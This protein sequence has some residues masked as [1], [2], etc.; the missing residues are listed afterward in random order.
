MTHR[1]PY[2]RVVEY[3]SIFMAQCA[4]CGDVERAHSRDAAKGYSKEHLRIVH[5]TEEQ[6][7]AD[8][9]GVAES[10]LPGCSRCGHEDHA[11]ASCPFVQPYLLKDK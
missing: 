8:R 11:S 6:Q 2:Q 7:E 10:E 1:W 9:L 3:G 4:E 5:P